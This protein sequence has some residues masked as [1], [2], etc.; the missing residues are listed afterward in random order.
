MKQRK[1]LSSDEAGVTADDI[2][3]SAFIDGELDGERREAVGRTLEGSIFAA[4]RA[5]AFRSVDRA[6]NRYADALTA[7]ELPARLCVRRMA[8]AARAR[9]IR[10]LS[11]VGAAFLL[12]VTGFGAGWAGHGFFHQQ[13]FFAR[14]FAE[15]AAAAH[16]VFAAD[17]RRPVE[18]G[19]DARTELAGWAGKRFDVPVFVPELDAVDLDYLGGRLLPGRLGEPAMQAMYIAKDGRR[20]TLYVAPNSS[21]HE[22]AFRWLVGSGVEPAYENVTI[23]WLENRTAFAIVGPFERETL[24]A[25]ASAVIEA[26]DRS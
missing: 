24:E 14:T 26:A 1:N 18:L 7:S 16:V 3:L 10:L 23:Y 5:A 2:D 25:V 22:T 17:V 8:A 6:V 19:P 21:G 12:V 4:R 11:I 13:T 9:R 20:L 15:N